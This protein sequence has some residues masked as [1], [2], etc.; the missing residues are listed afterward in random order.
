MVYLIYKALETKIT[1]LNFIERWGGL[2]IPFYD[3]FSEDNVERSYPISRHLSASEC[4]EQGKYK[5]LV[6][7]DQYKSVAYL[8]EVSNGAIGYT[9]NKGNFYEADYTVR[10][11][12]WL[13]FKKLG[14]EDDQGT[15]RFEL[16]IMNAIK[17]QTKFTV[18]GI[19][20]TVYVRSVKSI[21]RDSR[22][23]FGKWTYQKEDAFFF[24]PYG[25][26]ALDINCKLQINGGA[27]P[28]ITLGTEVTCLEEY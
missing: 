15:T 4:Y 8:E 2:V 23:I 21:E 7:N 16:A 22:A 28:E 25:Y 11:V 27:L 18:N 19:Q 9:S 6:P 3:K 10:L 17:R 26:F 1:T 13:N 5:N 24:W 12:C 20:G 14:L